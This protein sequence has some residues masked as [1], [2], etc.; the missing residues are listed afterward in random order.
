MN[1]KLK[2]STE[3]YITDHVLFVAFIDLLFLPALSPNPGHLVGTS[4]NMP[5]PLMDGQVEYADGTPATVTQV[6]STLSLHLVS[7]QKPPVTRLYSMLPDVIP[8]VVLS[9]AFVWHDLRIL[10]GGGCL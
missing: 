1:W 5:P 3:G 7:S 2:L 4:I 9:S 10:G 8:H 6:I